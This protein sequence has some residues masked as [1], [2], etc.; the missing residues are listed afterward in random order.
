MLGKGD[1][2]PVRFRVPIT[3]PVCVGNVP[4]YPKHVVPRRLLQ[5]YIPHACTNEACKGIA[6]VGT[7]VSTRF[8]TRAR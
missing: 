3:M 6:C 8:E 2:A 1:K 7:A 5:A 4:S